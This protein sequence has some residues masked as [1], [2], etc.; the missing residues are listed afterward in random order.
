MPTT[1]MRP[2]EYR[3]W[4]R[5]QARE[6]IPAP[7]DCT[8][9]VP[10]TSAP[11]SKRIDERIDERID[12]GTAAGQVRAES[13]PR[14]TGSRSSIW[15][16]RPARPFP[17]QRYPIPST[18][19]LDPVPGMSPDRSRK[20]SRVGRAG[21]GRQDRLSAPIDSQVRCLWVAS[22]A[23]FCLHRVVRATVLTSWPG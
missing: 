5:S 23:W 9:G 22:G 19:R 12:G 1:S 21:R 11:A 8:A 4:D 14:P 7:L 17:Q 10:P 16:M 3:R 6:A 18:H 15:S 2:H 20:L 13:H